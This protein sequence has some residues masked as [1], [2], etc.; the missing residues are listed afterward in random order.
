MNAFLPA[1]PT[2]F[3]AKAV[4]RVIDSG[5]TI[6]E[7]ARELRLNEFLLRRW[8]ADERTC[9]SIGQSG[10]EADLRL[11]ADDGDCDRRRSGRRPSHRQGRKG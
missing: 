3:K 1:Y 7:V 5:H 11:A 9:R 4:S 8:L 2:E 6:A 10:G